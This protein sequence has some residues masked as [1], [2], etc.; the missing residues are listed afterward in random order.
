MHDETSERDRR[1]FEA[2]VRREQTIRDMERE[3]IFDW[4]MEHLDA[5]GSDKKR[6]LDYL[7]AAP[8]A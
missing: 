7:E 5:T 2:G 3:R 8:D 4:A 1:T 6:L